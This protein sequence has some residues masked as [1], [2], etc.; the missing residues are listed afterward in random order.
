[1]IDAGMAKDSYVVT[2]GT[3]LGR[4]GK[5]FVDRIDDDIWIGGD[6]VSCIEGT[7]DF[8]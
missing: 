8:G 6:V 3:A 5:V 1:L 7:V 4:A 2:Q